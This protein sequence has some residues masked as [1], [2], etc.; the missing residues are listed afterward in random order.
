MVASGRAFSAASWLKDPGS[1][2]IAMRTLIQSSAH[3]YPNGN[4][5][6]LSAR[7]S[8]TLGWKP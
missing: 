8:I 4:P 7:L 1:P 5:N 3:L 6:R 2:W